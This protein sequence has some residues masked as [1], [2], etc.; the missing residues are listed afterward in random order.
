MKALLFQL[1]PVAYAFSASTFILPLGQNSPNYTFA[2]SIPKN[3]T[4]IYFH[5]SGPTDYSWVAVGTGRNMENS[6]MV[7][8]YAAANG[9][10]VTVSPRLCSGHQ[11]PVYSSALAVDILNG[12]GIY[13]NTMTLNARCSNCVHWGTGSLDL[14]SSSQSWIY[15]LG[16]SGGTAAMLRSNSKTA[17]IER[18]SRY[19][20]LLGRFTMDMVRAISD[21]AGLPASF[22]TAAGSNMDG[23][24]TIDSNWPSIIHALCLCGTFVIMMPLGVTFLRIFPRS[25]RWHWINQT[26]SSTITFVGFIIGIYL[27]T[28]FTKSEK[29][30]STHQII[31]IMIGLAL[32]IQLGMGSWHHW[33]F[34]RTNSPT[35]F[36]RIHRYFGHIVILLGIINGGIGLT[37]SYASRSVVIGYSIAVLIICL[38]YLVALWKAKWDTKHYKRSNVSAVNEL[39]QPGLGYEL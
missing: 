4:D 12:T 25:V 32:I 17:S 29:A 37:W 33:V 10:N 39:N 26:L 28:M 5:L 34:K 36:G 9:K 21:S 30:N 1:L 7:L 35:I 31:G 16:P 8:L 20:V 38:V 23:S 3:S 2:L 6:L 14:K 15:A 24:I 13:G 27:S 18:H 11:E 22:T 19:A